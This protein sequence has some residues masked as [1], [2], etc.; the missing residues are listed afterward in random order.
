SDPEASTEDDETKDGAVP[1]NCMHRPRNGQRRV[2]NLSEYEV[3][4]GLFM[5]P[6]DID[7]KE[8]AEAVGEV[9]NKYNKEDRDIQ[10]STPNVAPQSLASKEIEETKECG[11]SD[12][13]MIV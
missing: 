11:H 9:S 10:A 1:K 5:A 6:K 8:A 2:V 12:Q 13:Q 7:F 3:T 4:A